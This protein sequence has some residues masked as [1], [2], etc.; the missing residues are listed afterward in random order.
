MNTILNTSDIGIS[1]TPNAPRFRNSL[2]R[3]SARG[4]HGILRSRL[5]IRDIADR[6][7]SLNKLGFSDEVINRSLGFKL[8]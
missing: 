5:N 7:V 3:D 1:A 8:L 6:R 4:K 2:D